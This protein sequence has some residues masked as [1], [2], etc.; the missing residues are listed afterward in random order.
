MNTEKKYAAPVVFGV[1]DKFYYVISGTCIGCGSCATRCPVHAIKK[2][3]TQYE[4]IPLLCID[5]GTCAYLC[6]VG[7]PHPV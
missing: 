4:I 7:A 6:P 2:G 5:C 1:E 3:D